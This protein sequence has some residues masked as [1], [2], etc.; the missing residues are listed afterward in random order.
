LI[1]AK[2]IDEIFQKG[3]NALLEFF[4]KSQKTANRKM[5]KSQN[6][7]FSNW[8]SDFFVPLKSVLSEY[9]DSAS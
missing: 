1:F 2:K 8:I 4:R 3:L 9:A 5:G 6:T 7:L